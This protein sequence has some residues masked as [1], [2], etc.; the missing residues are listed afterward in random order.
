MTTRSKKYNYNIFLDGDL[1]TNNLNLG[2]S[3]IFSGSFGANNNVSSPA[4]VTGLSFSNSETRSFQCQL[5]VTITRSVGG[6]F[7]ELFSLEGHQTDSGWN[8]YATSLNDI[9]GVVFTITNSGQ[10]QYTSTDIENFQ[11]SIFRFVVTQIANVGTYSNLISGTQGTYLLNSIHVFNTS[12]SVLG[13]NNGAL[14]VM[15]GSTFEKQIVIKTTTN[16][17][18]LGTGGAL[19]VFGGTS[20]SKDLLIGG[21]LGIGISAPNSDLDVNGSIN[22]SSL[23]TTTGT[24]ENLLSTSISSSNLN[25]SSDCVFG[26][27][28]TIDQYGSIS[29]SDGASYKS[30]K[31][32]DSQYQYSQISSSNYPLYQM[33][34][35]NG[36]DGYALFGLDGTAGAT[37]GCL[38]IQSGAFFINTL[39]TADILFGTNNALKMRIRNSGI[40]DITTGLSTGNIINT[41][42]TITNV[43]STNITVGTLVSTNATAT[44]IVGTTI[45]AS[46]AVATTYTGGSMSLSGDL[47]L[48][49]TLTT[50]N[51]TTTNISET[52][53]SAGTVTATNTNFTTQTVGTSRITTNLLALGNSNTVGSLYTTGGNVGVGITNPSYKMHIMG[54]NDIISIESTDATSRSS[55]KFLTNGSDW[56]LG[57]R[58]SSGNPDNAFYLYDNANVRYAFAV[59]STGNV[60]IGTANPAYTLDVN[61]TGRFTGKLTITGSN[62]ATGFDTATNDQYADMRVIRNS[63]SSLD[64]DMYIQNGAGATSSLHMYSNNSET[65]TLKSGKVGVNNTNPSAPLHVT[66]TSSTVPENNGIYCY[67]STNSANQHSI[68][69]VRTAGP[70]GGNPYVSWDINTVAGWSMGI[71]N[72]D[73]DKLKISAAWDSLSFSKMT[74]SGNNI[75]IMTDSPSSTLHVNGS[76]IA[77]G[78]NGFSFSSDADA[79]ARFGS[80]LISNSTG[81]ARLNVQDRSANCISFYTGTTKQGGI[82]AAGGNTS[83]NFNSGTGTIGSIRFQD[84]GTTSFYPGA[85]L[86]L[87]SSGVLGGSFIVKS[88]MVQGSTL[89][90]INTQSPSYPLDVTGNGRVNGNLMIASASNNNSGINLPAG[91]YGIHW[92]QGYSRIYD[93]GDLRI[94]TDDNMHFHNG[95]TTSTPGTERMTLLQNGNFGIGE[96]NPPGK[97]S[98][99]TASGVQCNMSIQSGAN[100][101]F[102]ISTAQGDGNNWMYIGGI[103]GTAPANGAI[104]IQYDGR[105]EIP[106][107]LAKSSGTFDIE[108]PLDSEYRLIHSFIEGPRCDLIYRGSVQLVDGIAN[109][110]IDSECV[111][112]PESAMRQGTF[113]SLVAN[114]D[115]FLQ[116]KTSFDQV[117]GN[118][119]GNILTIVSNN[120][121]SN[122]LISWMVIGERKDSFIKSWNQT[123][124]DGYLITEYK[125]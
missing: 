109:V 101:R 118:I 10:V 102:W 104:K 108:H 125:I 83:F 58:G 90:G 89:V 70:N 63:T 33:L 65:M 61:G 91:G 67:N 95:S 16:A 82:T 92:G 123:T 116:N 55:I 79:Y 78:N 64:K 110:N 28:T 94:C 12:N 42:S 106:G 46:T 4:N 122:A 120:T 31:T 36:S 26:S 85:T 7:Y 5:S 117:I 87:D 9:T 72:S 53:V 1:S 14:Y 45:S 39:T 119:S 37:S 124:S 44:N 74:F 77:G 19:S 105:V 75:G 76:F 38:G 60:G 15:G 107:V 50:V 68:V 97:F 112:N 6:N 49:G 23:Y 20:I 54:S 11:N 71:D 30:Y 52:N 35:N 57:A 48:A 111:C 40:V 43:R 24:V 93:D 66:P 62:G 18:G 29:I 88:N 80:T 21:K 22:S 121:T 8:L 96:S 56:E 100:S 32:S 115:I 2:V 59:T 84:A 25:I 13:S 34:A 81:D 73:G 99:L 98:L 51:I 86:A 113:E 27:N 103:G 17:T 47:T 3:T 69:S 114:P 41:N